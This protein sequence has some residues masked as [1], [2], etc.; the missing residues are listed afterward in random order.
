MT[1]KILFWADLVITQFGIAKY[2]KKHN[3]ELYAIYNLNPK[4][5]PEFK[6]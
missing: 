3:C 1:N 6:N 2:L 5:K 4:I